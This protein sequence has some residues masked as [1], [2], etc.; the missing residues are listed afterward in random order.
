MYSDMDYQKNINIELYVVLKNQLCELFT[1]G[2]VTQHSENVL[3]GKKNYLLIR[4]KNNGPFVSWGKISCKV[5]RHKPI[6]IEV[7]AMES[8]MEEFVDHLIPIPG[9]MQ[10][11]AET[12][13]EISCKWIELYSY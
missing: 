3:Y 4:M 1:S 6:Q 13:P 5:E 8:K 11:R 9:I 12:L 2:R 10:P 7:L